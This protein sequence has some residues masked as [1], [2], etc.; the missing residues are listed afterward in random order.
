MLT[1]AFEHEDGKNP[2]CQMPSEAR[3]KRNELLEH[4]AHLLVSGAAE[5][6]KKPAPGPA[7]RG[8]D[9]WWF[10]LGTDLDPAGMLG[11]RMRARLSCLKA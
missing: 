4:F 6:D 8:G 3:Q 9:E 5:S 7:R 11:N 10:W 2:F 1:W